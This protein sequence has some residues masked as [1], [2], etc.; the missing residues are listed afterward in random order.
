[1]KRH[2]AATI[3]IVAV[4]L[5]VAG[6]FFSGYGFARPAPRPDT[7]LIGGPAL[8]QNALIYVAMEK[9]FFEANG[10]NVT[11]REDY[12]NGVGPVNDLAAGNVDVSV[13]SEYPVIARIISGGD[14]GIIATID[15]YQN[16]E[17]ISRKDAGI[18]NITDLRGKRIGLPRGT[19]LE[20]F[21]GILLERNGMTIG[22]VHLV[23][24]NTTYSADAVANG[25]VDAIM[26]FQPYVSR[27]LDR[28]GDNAVTWPGQSNQ[29]LYGV[30]AARGD[31]VQDNAGT[32][33][34]LLQ[35]LEDAQEYSI[36]HPDE[37][38]AIVQKHLNLSDE[39]TGS[40]WPDH[41]FSLSLDQSLLVA[42][43]DEG[44][45]M[46][47]NNLTTEKTLPDFRTHIYGQGLEKIRPESVD[48][49]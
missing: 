34:R 29:A 36:A 17:L 14:I 25:D 15:K 13:S 42:M 37:T 32:V 5:A 30:L 40:V 24:V 26:Y 12:P 27:I 21:L 31:W 4:I 43:N 6:I 35:S 38:E 47:I 22:D 28:L 2:I 3:V 10:L 16:E 23:D 41:R 9:G 19:I 45:W 8:E 7:V 39:Y 33:G 49:R 11:L 20:Y 18:R 46:I 48:I 44:R 1:M